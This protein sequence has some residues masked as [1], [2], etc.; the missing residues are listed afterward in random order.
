M[1]AAA[2]YTE[3]DPPQ[4]SNNRRTGTPGYHS[5]KQTENTTEIH[6]HLAPT[7]QNNSTKFNL[8]HP[9]QNLQ[10]NEQNTIEVLAA[11]NVAFKYLAILSMWHP[12]TWQHLEDGPA[13][14]QSGPTQ[15]IE[16]V[17]TQY[18]TVNP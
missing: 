16:P 1:E 8:P 4:S 10:E 15:V 14:A 6:H 7:A 2:E 9:T 5:N 18:S 12:S 13:C 17:Y 11:Q 3:A